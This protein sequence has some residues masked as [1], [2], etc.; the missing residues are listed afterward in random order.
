LKRFFYAK[1]G[2]DVFL[3]TNAYC[4]IRHGKAYSK[5]RGV[6]HS[7]LYVGSPSHILEKTFSEL[8]GRRDFYDQ[9]AKDLFAR[10]LTN[11]ESLHVT[12]TAPGAL[13]K[14]TTDIGD[15]FVRFI[16]SPI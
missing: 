5:A 2:E 11:L 6:D 12:L 13:S 9:I 8:R 15:R 3:D 4:D 7:S 10:G 16:T 14:R 1:Q